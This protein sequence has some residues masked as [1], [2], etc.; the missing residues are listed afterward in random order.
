MQQRRRVSTKVIA[1][2][3][4]VGYVRLWKFSN[5]LPAREIGTSSAL[6]WLASQITRR[7]SWNWPGLGGILTLLGW[8]SAL[9]H[10]SRGLATY[11]CSATEAL[12]AVLANW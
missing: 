12:G 1:V 6:W 3:N 4:W 5:S 11:D 8:K 10:S 2:G 9:R 7:T